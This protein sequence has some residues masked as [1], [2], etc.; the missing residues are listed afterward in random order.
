[1]TTLLLFS[2][3]H[4]DVVAA[5]Q[6][7]RLSDQAQL[8]IGAGDFANQHR[9]LAD[10]LSLVS[11]LAIPLVLVPGNNETADALRVACQGRENIHVLH[12]TGVSLAGLKLFGVGGGI[13]NTPFGDW[14]Y[15]FSEAEATALL[16]PCHDCDILV[17]HSPPWGVVDRS[18]QGQ[19]LGSRAIRDATLRLRPKLHI[20]GHIHGSGGQ[21]AKLEQTTVINAGPAGLLWTWPPESL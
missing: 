15:D 1:M 14:S 17:T 21:Q 8:A 20:C 7:V 5:R 18:S 4:R 19:H 13:P 11:E 6:L 3:L 9:G 2:D 10:C 12:G 16:A